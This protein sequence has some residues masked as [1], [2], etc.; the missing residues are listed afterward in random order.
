MNNANKEK[1]NKYIIDVLKKYR[2]E[3]IYT[4]ADLAKMLDITRTSYIN[5]EAGR[6]FLSA[7]KIYI[8]SCVFKKP[9]QSFFPEQVSIVPLITETIKTVVIRKDKKIRNVKK[10]TL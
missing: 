5:I 3:T 10:I 6:H 9:I 1:V 2:K 4:Q 8:L 7:D